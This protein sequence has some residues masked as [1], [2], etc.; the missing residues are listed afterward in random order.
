MRVEQIDLEWPTVGTGRVNTLVL[1][2]L[3]ES[4]RS[5]VECTYSFIPALW[6]TCVCCA[7]Q[8]QRGEDAILVAMDVTARVLAATW[9]N[10]TELLTLQ[11]NIVDEMHR[12]GILLSRVPLARVCCLPWQMHLREGCAGRNLRLVTPRHLQIASAVAVAIRP[13][14]EFASV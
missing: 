4:W 12:R 8:S 10:R 14:L 3:E 7:T 1:S 5:W 13:V 2:A 6:R 11:V 9:H